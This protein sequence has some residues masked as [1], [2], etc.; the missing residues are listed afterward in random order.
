MVVCF[1]VGASSVAVASKLEKLVDNAKIFTFNSIP[2]IV[3]DA[4]L[5]HIS[6]NRMIISNA[7]ITN[8]ENDLTELNNFIKNYSS[9]TEIIILLND[10][11]DNMDET[12]E[13]F[14]RLFNSP[15]YA[16]FKLSKTTVKIL[17]DLTAKSMLEITEKY[18]SFNYVISEKM[19]ENT[20]VSQVQSNI[21]ESTGKSER[22]VPNSEGN[23]YSENSGSYVGNDSAFGTNASYGEPEVWNNS[24]SIS[25]GGPVDSV[26]YSDSA[27]SEEEL[28]LS[29]GEFG[30][31]HSDTGYLC[32]EDEE[33]LDEIFG[34]NAGDRQ[35]Q[36]NT[37]PI[38]VIKTQIV[39][40]GKEKSYET[41]MPIREKVQENSKVQDIVNSNISVFDFKKSILLCSRSH[42][43]SLEIIDTAL[44][45][46]NTKHE[47]VLIVDLDYRQNT[48]L[49]YLNS[50][51]MYEQGYNNGIHN[52]K[53]YIEDGVA[54]VS[55]GYGCKVNPKDVETLF[56]SV[57]FGT[58]ENVFVY[59]PIDCVDCIPDDVL[60]SLN[61]RLCVGGNLT[62]FLAVSNDICN[63]EYVSLNKERYILAN[64]TVEFTRESTTLED[65]GLLSQRVFFANGSWVDRV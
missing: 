17:L 37:K 55:N 61:I 29:L 54:I 45:I 41:P 5:R 60:K 63:R 38:G 53:F 13:L 31:S 4:T 35:V 24:N 28:D 39:T 36:E 2:E 20:E 23:S 19:V 12:G 43:I 59:C 18:K 52:I 64:C 10:K 58:Y 47:S 7:I 30:S 9:N 65:M 40:E 11:Y 27:F 22:L 50:D 15:M 21:N 56:N 44:N 1:S 8:V 62:T 46:V 51:K 57:Q 42:D 48:I 6:Y 33:E 16:C 34:N 3:K 14:N 49:S 32:S 26:G 25:E